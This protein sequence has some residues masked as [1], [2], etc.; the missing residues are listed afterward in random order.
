MKDLILTS[1]LLGIGL[2]MDAFCVSLAS[3]LNE[4]G[5]SGKRAFAICGTFGAFQFFMP[6]IGWVCVH[7][8]SEWFAW[9]EKLIPWIALILLGFI[10]IKMIVE[11][12]KGK[13]EDKAAGMSAGTLFVMGIATSIDALS[14]G[15]AISHYNM[16]E[17]LLGSLIIGVVTLI[18]CRAGIELGRK[19]GTKLAGKASVLGGIILLAIGIEIFVKGII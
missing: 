3:G 2:A 7:T 1:F 14:V 19:V 13:E 12:L 4:P 9:F 11:G 15:F 6:M 5:M 16:K 8:I 18:I 10:G 17:A